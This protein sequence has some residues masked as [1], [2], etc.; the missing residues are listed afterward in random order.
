MIPLLQDVICHKEKWLSEE[1]M[2]DCI[3][4]SQSLPGVIA[5]NMATYVGYRKKGILGAII[6]TLGVILPG[7]II[8]ILVIR[9]LDNIGNNPYISGALKGIKIAAGGLIALSAYGIGRQTISGVRAITYVLITFGLTA[10][11][12]VNGIWIIAAGIA[13][14]IVEGRIKNV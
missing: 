11:L 13:I 1:E 3:S 8:I 10:F 4:I 2:I 14:G 12:G 7:F 9:L 5:V 6:S